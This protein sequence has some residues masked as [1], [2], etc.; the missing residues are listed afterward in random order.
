MTYTDLKKAINQ[1]IASLYTSNT[2]KI[3]SDLQVDQDFERPC[4]FTS[5]VP[6]S[7]SPINYNTIDKKFDI[8]ITYFPKQVS[9]QQILNLIELI[10]TKFTLGFGAGTDRYIDVESFDWKYTSK[11]IEIVIGIR[12]QDEIDHSTVSEL[13]QNI[14]INQS[15]ILT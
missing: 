2:P 9:E 4:F 12:Y 5:L 6:V 13:M 15:I 14:E 1:K 11:Q 7:I 3:Y 8:I 10:E